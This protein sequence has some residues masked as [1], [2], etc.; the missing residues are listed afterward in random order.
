MM[1]RQ[2]YGWAIENLVKNAI[3]A[4]KGQ[5]KVTIEIIE[6]GGIKYICW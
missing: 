4:M 3:D 2:L 1:N 6:N 5:G